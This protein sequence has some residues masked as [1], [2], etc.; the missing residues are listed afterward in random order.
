M[1]GGRSDETLAKARVLAGRVDRC[2]DLYGVAKGQPAEVLERGTLAPAE[3]PTD[4]AY[5]LSKLDPGE[6]STALTRANGQT[7]VFLMLCGRT[8]KLNEDVNREEFSIGLRNRRLTALADGYLAQ[9]RA[10]A[11]IINR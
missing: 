9:L 10:D 11:R 5:E 2:D 6:V 7:L 3:V 4:I 1:P 8:T